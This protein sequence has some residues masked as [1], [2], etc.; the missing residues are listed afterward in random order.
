MRPPVSPKPFPWAWA[1]IG[2]I[3]II[4]IISSQTK[5]A[6]SPSRVAGSDEAVKNTAG[7]ADPVPTP[8]P[9]LSETTLKLA[10]RHA[11]LALGADGVDG[12]QTYSENCWA[13]LERAFT[14]ITAE[15]CAAFD[16]LVLT[17]ADIEPTAVPAWFSEETV[18]ARYGR[19]LSANSLSDIDVNARLER[20]RVACAVQTVKKVVSKPA[21]IEEVLDTDDIATAAT[22]AESDG[23]MGNQW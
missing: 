16:A 6:A 7:A 2:G 22:T 17:N 15:R 5:P 4:L 3:I 23:A 18:A 10:A 11:G 13:S 12:A 19:A 14:L 8:P 21:P 20:L 9:A 1:L